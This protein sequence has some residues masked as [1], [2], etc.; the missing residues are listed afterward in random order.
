MS[1]VPDQAD[2][3]ADSISSDWATQ[4]VDS[5]EGIITT[6]R[7]KTTDPVRNVARII[8]FGVMIVGL[9]IATFFLVTI[10]LIRL[11]DRYIPMGIWL[12]YLILGGLFCCGGLFFW[13]RRHV[14]S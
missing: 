9:A 7:S 12:P 6:I 8:V 11:A 13:T 1:D 3:A 14:R 4:L 5:L 2:T 10:G